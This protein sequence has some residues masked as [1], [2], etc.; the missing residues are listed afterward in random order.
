M[1]VRTLLCVNT[2]EVWRPPSHASSLGW[3]FCSASSPQ[4]AF[5][6][7]AQQAPRVGLVLLNEGAVEAVEALF[8][9][10]CS[11]MIWV[12]LAPPHLLAQPRMQEQ[13]LNYCF[14]Y[15]SLPVEDDRLLAVLGH[16]FGIA[17]LKG[18]G[19]SPLRP[20]QGGGGYY[21]CQPRHAAADE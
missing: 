4:E 20:W 6:H 7:Y 14:D 8:R 11:T 19:S 5:R 16:A 21:R 12:A 3:R 1:E 2:S 15:H 9:Q 17:C 18:G 13:L 10:T